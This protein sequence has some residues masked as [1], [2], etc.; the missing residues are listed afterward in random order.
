METQELKSSLFQK[1]S[2]NKVIGFFIPKEKSGDRVSYIYSICF[3]ATF[4]LSFLGGFVWYFFHVSNLYPKINIV[5]IFLGWGLTL[6]SVYIMKYRK[7]IPPMLYRTLKDDLYTSLVMWLIFLWGFIA[8]KLNEYLL[9]NSN[10]TLLNIL[11]LVVYS[12]VISVI[13]LTIIRMQI[14]AYNVF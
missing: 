10:V 6:S 8:V 11:I 5:G 4:F 7:E 12:Y 9:E 3:K 2:D 13:I 14:R 1:I